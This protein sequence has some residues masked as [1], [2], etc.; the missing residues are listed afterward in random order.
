MTLRDRFSRAGAGRAMVNDVVE[1]TGTRSGPMFVPR[2]A[3]YMAACLR[4]FGE[5]SPAEAEVMT[6]C[7]GPGDVAVDVGASIGVFSLALGRSVGAS[8]TVYA[9]E[10]QR[11]LFEILCA[12]LMLN[13]VETV[14]AYP[15][16]VADR[17]SLVRFPRVDLA[18]ADGLFGGAA[19]GHAAR[20]SE[21]VRMISIDSLRLPRCRLIKADVEGWE[22]AVLRG[23]G[24]TIQAH[25]P[26]VIAEANRVGAFEGWLRALLR[27]GYRPFLTRPPLIGP[28]T[29]EGD[30][31]EDEEAARLARIV[32]LNVVAFPGDPPDW[33]E[34]GLEPIASIEA[35]QETVAAYEARAREA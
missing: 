17:E 23:A 26:V 10:P 2:N 5:Y 14:V 8:G 35:M 19:I 27:L 15:Y 31:A 30:A 34:L 20:K 33:P 32:S 6:R 29:W 11:P 12:N 24:R 4:R 13:R 18:E 7:V 22:G 16:A 3:R 25:R 1:L 28:D 21:V 9:F